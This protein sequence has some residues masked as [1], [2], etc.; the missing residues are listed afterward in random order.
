M[1]PLGHFV[2]FV[3]LL[4]VNTNGQH[5]PCKDAPIERDNHAFQRNLNISTDSLILCIADASGNQKKTL[6]NLDLMGITMSFLN[7]RSDVTAGCN[8][9]L[10]IINKEDKVTFPTFDRQLCPG[11]CRPVPEMRIMGHI[12][13][14]GSLDLT[15]DL[16]LTCTL[17]GSMVS[18]AVSSTSSIT[19]KQIG[20]HNTSMSKTM[21]KGRADP[22]LGPILRAM[23]WR[24][25]MECYEKKFWQSRYDKEQLKPF[26]DQATAPLS[27]GQSV[28]HE[29][30]R[31]PVYSLIVWIGSKSKS[32]LTEEQ[33]KV[34]SDQPFR[35]S[36]GVLGWSATDETYSC[37]LGKVKCLQ[38]RG[39]RYLPQSA[40]NFMSEGWGCAQRRPLRALAHTL[41]LVD[42]ELVIVLDDDTYFNYSLLQ[43]MYGESLT[44]GSMS[45]R[46]LLMGELIGNIGDEGHLSKWGTFAGGAGYVINKKAVQALTGYELKYYEGESQDSYVNI[47]NADVIRSNRH[48]FHLSLYKLGKANSEKYCSADE[49]EG[50]VCIIPGIPQPSRTLSSTT[51]LKFLNQSKSIPSKTSTTTISKFIA[52]ESENESAS[53][54]V[55]ISV[56]LIDF[57]TNMLANENTCDHRYVS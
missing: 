4:L 9:L 53:L 13:F 31:R 54:A 28:R 29:I 26:T 21:N 15:G 32:S 5:C 51:S 33:S 52:T 27:V 43:S 38:R 47:S 7:K 44:H 42:P 25:I 2:A 49:E 24:R 34:L 36:N 1:P 48:I 55:S 37:R 19:W 56:R 23:F 50:G 17:T 10:K 20:S 35:G 39:R 41:L 6:Q 12:L 16:L 45:V 40:I 11:V 57:C 3:F 46:A 8:V 22:Q 18:Y 30:S 14:G